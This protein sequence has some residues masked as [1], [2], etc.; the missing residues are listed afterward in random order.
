MSQICLPDGFAVQVDRRARMLGR[1][2][3]PV[4]LLALVLYRHFRQV[5]VIAAIAGGA[6]DWASRQRSFDNKDRTIGPLHYSL[7]DRL[8]D[9]AQGA[10]VWLGALREHNVGPLKPQICF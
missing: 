9:R 2:Y 8:A 6:M 7:L 10:G 1:Q 4:A 3:W 5:L